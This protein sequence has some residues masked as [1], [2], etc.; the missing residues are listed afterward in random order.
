MSRI[1]IVTDSTAY[2]P[3]ELLKKL[4]ISVVP[5]QVQWNGKTYDEADPQATDVLQALRNGELATTSRPS[6][7]RFTAL[8]EKLA[9]DGAEEIV[10]IHISSSMSGTSEAAQL[11]ASNGS[12]PIHVIDSRTVGMA[13][14][15][16]VVAAALAAD[17]GA[18]AIEVVEAAR[19]RISVTNIFFS[20]AKLE[21]LRRSG[22]IS[23]GASLLAT[24]L[25]I[26]PILTVEDGHVVAKERVRTQTGAIKR[27]E[28]MALEATKNRAVDVAIHHLGAPELAATF[29]ANLKAV[30]SGVGQVVIS[31]V[32]AVVGTHVGPGAIAVVIAPRI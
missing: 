25:A 6:P 4:A 19:Q 14:G 31:E 26:K 32:G 1:A 22:R 10:S 9:K 7:E 17:E 21:N 8:Y 18:S 28:E 16:G 15:F 3:T 5:L 27:L 2:L 23:R 12:I 24:A 30:L 13:M 29:A 20:V 11:A